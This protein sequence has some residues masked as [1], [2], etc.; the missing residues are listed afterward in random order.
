MQQGN[1]INSTNYA[2]GR[3]RDKI[4]KKR[5]KALLRQIHVVNNAGFICFDKVAI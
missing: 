3:Q 4:T 5:N 1:G 2:T